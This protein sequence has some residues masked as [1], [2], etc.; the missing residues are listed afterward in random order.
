MVDKLEPAR[1]PSSRLGERSVARGANLAYAPGVIQPIALVDAIARGDD[2][3]LRTRLVRLQL[4]RAWDRLLGLRGCVRADS[5]RLARVWRELAQRQPRPRV[6]IEGAPRLRLAR[7]REH[8]TRLHAKLL[9]DTVVDVR[10]RVVVGDKVV[11]GKL[12]IEEL[13]NRARE[14]D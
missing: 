7:V 9:L 6:S 14:E 5:T 13:E 10:R 2:G 12:R 8:L 3:A 4:E 1:L 11:V